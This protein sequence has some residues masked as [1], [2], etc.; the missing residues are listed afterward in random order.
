MGKDKTLVPFSLLAETIRL[1]INKFTLKESSF[2]YNVYWF[3]FTL[4]YIGSLPSLNMNLQY[5]DPKEEG[6]LVDHAEGGIHRRQNR[7]MA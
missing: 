3:L 1:Q 5:R 7:P 2:F 4:A 6:I